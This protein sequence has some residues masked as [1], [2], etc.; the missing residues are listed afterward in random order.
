VLWFLADKLV[1][2]MHGAETKVN[3]DQFE[4]EVAVTAAHEALPESRTP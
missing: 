3:V 1:D 2:W 4:D